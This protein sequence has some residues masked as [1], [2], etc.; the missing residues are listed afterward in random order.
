MIT[1]TEVKVKDFAFR[2]VQISFEAPPV[3]NFSII[4][5]KKEALALLQ[6]LSA[7]QYNEHELIAHQARLDSLTRWIENHK[8]RFSITATVELNTI[9]NDYKYLTIKAFEES[10]K[11]KED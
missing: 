10:Q 1:R 3:V 7:L 5:D 8:K 9:L 11:K 2:T 4:L 6:Q